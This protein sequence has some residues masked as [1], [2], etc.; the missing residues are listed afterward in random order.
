V[1]VKKTITPYN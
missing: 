1:I